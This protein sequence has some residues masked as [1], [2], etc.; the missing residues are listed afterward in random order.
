MS[1]ITFPSH[2]SGKKRVVWLK[3]FRPKKKTSSLPEKLIR[4]YR[5]DYNDVIK[6]R[7]YHDLNFTTNNTTF[8]YSI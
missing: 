8:M 4:N 2:S 7:Y 1:E 6:L 3:S 5:S